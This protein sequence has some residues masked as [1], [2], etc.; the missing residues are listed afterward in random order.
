MFDSV[1]LV[2]YY[3]SLNDNEALILEYIRKGLSDRKYENSQK[4]YLTANEHL[5]TFESNYQI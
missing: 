4:L 5:K 2:K 3:N 1:G